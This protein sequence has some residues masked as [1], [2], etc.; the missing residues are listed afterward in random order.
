[1]LLPT[2]LL[3][4]MAAPALPFGESLT[5]A[6]LAVSAALPVSAG[7]AEL[8]EPPFR[9]A[10]VIAEQIDGWWAEQGAALLIAAARPAPPVPAGPD[11]D[12]IRAGDLSF[13]FTLT[14]TAIAP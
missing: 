12:A 1:M 10:P 11:P 4:A 2:L 14:A 7:Y 8:R 3:A 5:D 9:L 6:E 13:R